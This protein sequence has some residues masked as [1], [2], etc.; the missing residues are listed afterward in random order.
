MRRAV[1]STVATFKTLV[2]QLASVYIRDS[3]G[4]LPRSREL[5]I[6]VPGNGRG[7][8]VFHAQT[9]IG[10]GRKLML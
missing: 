8:S 4:T 2:F 3:P 10:N 6:Q 9:H 1:G 7:Y 5:G